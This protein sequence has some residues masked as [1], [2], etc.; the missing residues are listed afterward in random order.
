[1]PDFVSILIALGVILGIIWAIKNR[2]KEIFDALFWKKFT[3]GA[4]IA[5]VFPYMVYYG[6]Q[7]FFE[8]PKYGDYITVE[9]PVYGDYVTDEKAPQNCHLDPEC[10]EQLIYYEEQLQF[11]EQQKEL[12]NEHVRVYDQAVEFHSTVEFIVWIAFGVAAI[13]GGI[14][15]KIPAAGMGITWGGIFSL[16]IGY[17]RYFEYMSEAMVF[18]SAILILIWLVW[19]AYTLFGK[20]LV[21][22]NDTDIQEK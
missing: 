6:I 20:E 12:H 16:G 5:L 2:P 18:I 3:L 7:T 22:R 14:L 10:N 9:Y 11:Y 8:Y 15:L 17:G 1:M 4:A 21:D 13:V 19:F